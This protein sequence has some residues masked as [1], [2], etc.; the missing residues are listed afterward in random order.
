MCTQMN[1]RKR[2]PLM[3][4]LPGLRHL[5]KAEVKLLCR[6][7][8]TMR[9][10][11]HA[12][13]AAFVILVMRTL[14][15]LNAHKTY[16]ALLMTLRHV[17]DEAL[18]YQYSEEVAA[19]VSQFRFMKGFGDLMDLHMPLHKPIIQRLVAAD[20]ENFSSHLDDIIMASF[21]C[22]LGRAMFG[23]AKPKAT[24]QHME[25]FIRRAC[26]MPENRKLTQA[27]IAI[28]IE[29]CDAE[30]DRVGADTALEFRM[31]HWH[32]L[33]K[34]LKP[35]CFQAP[36]YLSTNLDAYLQ[37]ITV[38]DAYLLYNTCLHV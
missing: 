18:T 8:M 38:F 28:I 9:P 13:V 14:H 5:T 32:W 11:A 16:P 22:E 4:L 23:W 7:C 6:C 3:V 35:L 26:K 33:Y 24:A 1:Q 19:K 10:S 37:Y 29:K 21:E 36:N 17:F 30:A 27:D 25:S 34:R 20:G 31:S 15:R 12:E 2:G